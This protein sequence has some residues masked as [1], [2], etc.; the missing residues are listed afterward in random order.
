MRPKR[1]EV[2]IGLSNASVIYYRL[3]AST[4]SKTG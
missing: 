4:V 2:A 1:D 3:H